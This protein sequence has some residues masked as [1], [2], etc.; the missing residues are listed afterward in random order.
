M[1]LFGRGLLMKP[2]VPSIWLFLM[3]R[4]KAALVEYSRYATKVVP[5]ASAREGARS[6]MRLGFGLGESPAPS[7]LSLK[8]PSARVHAARDTEARQWQW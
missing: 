1:Q 5:F 3:S 2:S 8:D 6:G 7:R 4:N